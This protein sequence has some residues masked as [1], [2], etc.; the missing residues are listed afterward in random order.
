MDRSFV[1]FHFEDFSGQ[2]TLMHAGIVTCDTAEISELEGM[3][4]LHSLVIFRRA[5]R[6]ISDTKVFYKWV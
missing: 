6:F 4:R 3:E 5:L 2:S 1:Q